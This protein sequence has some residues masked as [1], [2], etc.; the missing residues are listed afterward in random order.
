MAEMK[1]TYSLANL[2]DGLRTLI[3]I[4]GVPACGT[5]IDNILKTLLVIFFFP[6]QRTRE[7]LT[8]SMKRRRLGKLGVSTIRW[9]RA[10]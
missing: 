6:P 2:N 3:G 7:K 10:K 9:M 5:Q 4:L 1:V 8:R